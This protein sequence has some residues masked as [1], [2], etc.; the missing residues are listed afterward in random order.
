MLIQSMACTSSSNVFS[1]YALTIQYDPEQ[2]MKCQERGPWFTGLSSESC[3]HANGHWFPTPCITL[4]RCIDARPLPDDPFFNPQFEEW[5][6]SEE[7]EIYDA[8]DQDQW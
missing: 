5:V 8:S 6:E 4:Q 3:S 2:G 7:V 1:S